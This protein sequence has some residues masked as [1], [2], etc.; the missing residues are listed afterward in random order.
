MPLKK[1][2]S[3][4]WFS[5]PDEM[6][7]RHRAVLGTIGYDMDRIAGRPIIG[8]CNPVSEFNPCE[9][10]FRDII[11]AIKRGVI[12]A[13]GIPLEFP[14]M[15]LGAD[16]LKPADM[17]YRNLV[18]MDIEESIRGYPIDG[19]V[20]LCN[21]DK[22]TPAQLMA[23]ASAD[24][25]ALQFS[26]GAR[27]AGVFR[28]QLISSGADLWKYWDEYRTGAMSEVEWKQ[29]EACLACSHGA[30]NEMGTTS[31]MTTLSEALGMMPAG[32][33]AIPANDS[34]R[35][36]AAGAAGQRIVEMVQE[37]LR[38]SAILTQKA[39]ENAIRVCAAIGGST[40]AVIHLVAIAGRRGIHL[41][42]ALFDEL[43]NATPRLVNLQ[44]SGEYLMHHFH[45]AGGL[46]ALLKQMEPLLHL[47]CLTV[48]GQPLAQI[49]ASA[50]S[51]DHRVIR[52]LDNPLDHGGALAALTGNLV[53]GGAILKVSA[54]TPALLDH[55]GPALVFEG[56]EEMLARIDT[57][58][59]EVSP[60]TVLVMRNTGPCGVPGMPEWGQIPVPTKLLK[61]GI[62]DLVRISDAR[63]SG[64]SYGTVVLHAAPEAA[65][66]GPLAIVQNRDMIRLNVAERRLDLLISDQEIQER[67]TG[68][69]PPPR[70]HLRGYP[71]MYIEHVLQA[72][73]GCDFDFLRPE[74]DE[75][76]HFVPPQVGRS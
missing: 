61:Q 13:G 42:L 2:R 29:F 75:A 18:S 57:P 9:I 50:Q 7:L 16:L 54:A 21:C 39:F 72:N 63:M 30:C 47:D 40:N 34:R 68:W 67:L 10:G 38:P 48:S 76:L 64:T 31:T 36:I 60:E 70:R 74:S 35:L 37:D 15:A 27:T 52:P 55:T 1:L 66:G 4:D 8:I 23:A 20:L 44:P 26:A 6:G 49:I 53:P 11:P 19:V 3:A 45:L 14:T 73:E 71:R 65:V 22:T 24:I 43:F 59:L 51:Y 46:P 5:R 58:D 25:P 28:G 33:S 17:L 62:R 32:S 12:E 56:Y 41:P 69:S